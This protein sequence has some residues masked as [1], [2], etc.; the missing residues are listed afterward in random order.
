MTCAKCSGIRHEN[1]GDWLVFA[2]Q[3]DANTGQPPPNFK[4]AATQERCA[5]LKKAAP[6]DIDI[7]AT[8]RIY[9]GYLLMEMASYFIVIKNTAHSK[10]PYLMKQ[11]TT[12][13]KHGLE[14]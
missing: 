14:D 4:W 6:I 2:K 5:N 7:G 9:N 8:L 10:M 12:G 3:K 13:D 11:I 1:K